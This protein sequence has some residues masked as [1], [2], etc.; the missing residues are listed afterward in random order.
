MPEARDAAE[1]ANPP[2]LVTA[3]A[4]LSALGAL[5]LWFLPLPL[6]PAAHRL[7]AIV[8]AVLVAWVTEVLP[9]PVTAVLIAPALV[10]AD[11]APAKKAFAAYADPILFLF[12]G[13]FFAAKAMAR[14]GLDR[15]FA[16]AIANLPRLDGRPERLRLAVMLGAMAISMWIS[17][18]ATTA[19]LLPVLLG[20]IGREHARADTFAAGSVVALAHGSTIGGLATLVGTP[21]NAITARILAEAG[22][23]VSFLGWMAIGVPTMLVLTL[24]TYAVIARQLPA[25]DTHALPASFTAGTRQPWS[26]GERVTAL[27]FSLMVTGWL[28]PDIASSLDAPF[29]KALAERLEPGAVALLASSILFMVP[30]EGHSLG[31]AERV[32]EWRDAVQIEWGLVLL[33]GGG[34]A[35]GEAMFNTGLAKVLG[36]GFI[37]LTGATGLWSL[38]AAALAL[39][40]ILTEFCSNVAAANMLVPLVIGAAG[41]LDVSPIAP[42]VAAGLGASC[43]FML[44]V[45]TGANALVYGTGQV[46]TR[47][48]IGVGARVD[49]IAFVVV[50]ALLRL[51]CPL[52]GWS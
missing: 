33:F 31:R 8:W 51:L 21:P 44:P 23:R 35:L 40:I 18:T 22:Q 20:M 6:E 36:Q 34:I 32:L 24:A 30:M 49:L 15:R 37:A 46:S 16:R 28:L 43:G 9:L 5:L 47:A 50:F 11:I 45:A 48:M 26:R 19:L 52:L 2:W 13:S 39:A 1:T 27:S 41:E 29:A 4:L 12:V 7:A 14:H 3:G 42:A 38:T 25:G 10:L 17:N